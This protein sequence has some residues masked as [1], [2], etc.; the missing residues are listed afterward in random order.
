MSSYR[1]IF[2]ATG[3]LGSVQVLYVLIAVVRNKITALFIGA[4][5]MG[6]ADLYART[7]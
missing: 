4:A 2:R 6:L 5:G 1:H 7:V 3:L